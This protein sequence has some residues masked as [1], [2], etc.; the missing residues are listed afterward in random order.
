MKRRARPPQFNKIIEE[1]ADE[2]MDEEQRWARGVEKTPRV[3]VEGM[4]CGSDSVMGSSPLMKQDS[5]TQPSAIMSPK[6]DDS[7]FMSD[8]AGNSRSFL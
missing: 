6:A 2:Y 8:S 4:A 7:A 1:E 3:V 5:L